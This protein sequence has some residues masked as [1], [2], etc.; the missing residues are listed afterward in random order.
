MKYLALILLIISFYFSQ[1]QACRI[2]V[3]TSEAQRYI[4]ALEKT[5]QGVPPL[6]KCEDKPDEKCH[7]ADEVI[8]EEAELVTE[9][10]QDELGINIESKKLVNSEVKKAANEAKKQAEKELELSNKAA[11][12][13]LKLSIKDDIKNATTVAKLKAVIEKMIEAQE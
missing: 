7:C 13:A 5:G 4:D 2:Q 1:A 12:K 11:K 6:Y 3:P 10:S 8:W 9:F